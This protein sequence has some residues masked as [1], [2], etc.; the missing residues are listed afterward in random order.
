MVKNV[1]VINGGFLWRQISYLKNDEIMME[2]GGFP[3]YS[4]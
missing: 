1:N 3:S 4:L 2:S